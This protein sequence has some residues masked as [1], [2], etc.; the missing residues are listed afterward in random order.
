MKNGQLRKAHF[1]QYSGAKSFQAQVW[2]S[3][4]FSTR[5]LSNKKRDEL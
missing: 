1:M 3:V 4:F 5:F 2:E